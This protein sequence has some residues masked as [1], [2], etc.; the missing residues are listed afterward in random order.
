MEKPNIKGN[1]EPLLD[2][3]NSPHISGSSHRLTLGILDPERISFCDLAVEHKKK[4]C[5]IIKQKGDPG[6]DG[7]G[8]CMGFGRSEEDD[9]PCQ[10]CKRCKHCTSY[11]EEAENE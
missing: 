10:P 8:K 7:N 9:E 6:T 2:Q 11:E 4:H 1:T 3:D 5:E